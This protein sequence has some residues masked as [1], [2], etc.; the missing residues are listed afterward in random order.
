MQGRRKSILSF[1]RSIDPDTAPIWIFMWVAL[2]AAICAAFAP[3]FQSNCTDLKPATRQAGGSILNL[4]LQA[5]PQDK[6]RDAVDRGDARADHD[7]WIAAEHAGPFY[8]AR[9]RH[10]TPLPTL[11]PSEPEVTHE[12]KKHAPMRGMQSDFD[13]PRGPKRRAAECPQF[14]E[15][16]ESGV[17]RESAVRSRSVSQSALG[18]EMGSPD[19]IAPAR[20]H[21]WRQHSIPALAM[22]SPIHG[23]E[24]STILP[25]RVPLDARVGKC[26]PSTGEDDASVGGFLI[27]G[28]SSAKTSWP[29]R[30]G[31]DS[32]ADPISFAKRI[33]PNR[34]HQ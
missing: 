18:N 19:L 25:R 27:G 8:P 20:Q 22:E 13:P 21:R 14:S 30:R 17:N 10:T 5:N 7:Q 9:A 29:D 4:N 28:F 11:L 33:S 1:I 31:T 16:T 26:P 12:V 24:T 3:C 15:Q 2:A 34:S 32:P 6:L 23:R